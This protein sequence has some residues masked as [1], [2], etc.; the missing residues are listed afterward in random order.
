MPVI[1]QH[2]Q[3]YPTNCEYKLFSG[4]EKGDMLLRFYDLNHDKKVD[5]KD[6]DLLSRYVMNRK[7]YLEAY[8]LNF[9]KTVDINDIVELR[10]YI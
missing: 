10:S 4:I 7:P 2:V 8:D 9:D 6:L 3:A 5:I 1:Y